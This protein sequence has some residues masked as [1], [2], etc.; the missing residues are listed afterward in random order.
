MA[1]GKSKNSSSNN[2]ATVIFSCG[3]W[4]IRRDPVAAE[5]YNS[6][7]TVEC[8]RMREMSEAANIRRCVSDMGGSRLERLAALS[9]AV[10]QALSL[11][12]YGQSSPSSGTT[13]SSDSM[14]PRNFVVPLSVV[15]EFFPQ[16][17]QEASTGQNLTA[18]GNP[19][20]TRSVIYAT[21]DSSKKVT[22][23][24]DQYESS[25]DASSAYEQ[26]VEKSKIPGFKSVSVPNVGQEAFAGTVTMEAETHVGLG[27]LAGKLI[28]GVTLA[29]YDATPDN[30]AKLVALARKEEAAARAAVG[31]SGDQ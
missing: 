20:A 29:G 15:D 30:I 26:A 10:V 14:L 12:A 3:Q 21:G 9:I 25:T 4:T 5:S 8:E 28:V 13:S 2:S 24:V 7:Q 17:T 6:R 22:I 1:S 23:T 19:K 16:V 31:A 27:A 18:V 11:A